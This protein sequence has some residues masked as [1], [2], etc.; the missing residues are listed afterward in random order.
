MPR[1]L[2][3]A[4]IVKNPHKYKIKLK[5][6]PVKPYF[7][8]VNVGFQINLAKAAKMAGITITELYRLNPGFNRWSTDPDG[9]HKLLLPIEKLATFENN[10][11]KQTGKHSK[12]VRHVVKPNESLASIGT[13]YHS[14]AH[15]I[16]IANDLDNLLVS[17]SQ[18]LLIP[19]N[20]NII[21]KT[22]HAAHVKALHLKYSNS[23]LHIVKNGDSLWK[24]SK[25]Y[26]VSI[27]QILLANKQINNQ[28]HPGQK[29]HIPTTKIAANEHL[30]IPH[31]IQS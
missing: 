7:T 21:T 22:A 26:H 15:A 27:D 13:Q 29:L 11:L 28:I 17:T 3:L 24:I 10:L 9:P 14:S 5:P 4:A 12:L 23:G 30:V 19:K 18:V 8:E 6:L 25:R 20:T 16:K 2:A 31:D 1:L